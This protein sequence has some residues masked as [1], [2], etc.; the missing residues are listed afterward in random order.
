V[1][2]ICYLIFAITVDS[3]AH[4]DQ[5]NWDECLG[6]DISPGGVLIA[7]PTIMFAYTCQVNVF[8]IYQELDKPTARRIN[9]VGSRSCALS[10]CLYALIGVFGFLRFTD[11]KYDW[12]V[13]D[14]NILN[15]YMLGPPHGHKHCT[16]DNCWDSTSLDQLLKTPAILIGEAAI[17]LT[18]LLAFPL[19]V[20]PCR[21]TIEMMLFAHH[22]K[23]QHSATEKD[24]AEL[25]SPGQE[26]LLGKS[27]GRRSWS[28]WCRHF[29]LTLG[30]VGLAMVLAMFVPDIQ[31]VFSLLGSTTSA[32]VCYIVPAMF[33]LKVEPEPWYHRKQLPAFCLMVGGIITGI[34]CTGVIIYEKI[35]GGGSTKPV[36]NVT[37]GL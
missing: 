16:V 17:T 19:N 35:D 6:A 3:L 36:L 13:T 26:A 29:F 8:S 23:Q 20:F 24:A 15:N 10:C 32:F 27:D 12:D 1:G 31:V 22:T 30:I 18:I 7:I 37:A 5:F 9:K 33:V 11:L 14:G 28:E 34:V 2:S 25:G 4:Y 21:Y